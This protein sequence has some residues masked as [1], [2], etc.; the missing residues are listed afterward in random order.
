MHTGE[1]N[2]KENR[3]FIS[4]LML[5]LFSCAIVMSCMTYGV[6]MKKP[7]LEPE[8]S[9]EFENHLAF[10]REHVASETKK[11]EDARNQSIAEV[12][13]EEAAKVA[14]EA[15]AKA[16]VEA[17]VKVE[18]EAKL[19]SVEKLISEV[20]AV[21]AANNPEKVASATLLLAE[22]KD[23]LDEHPDSLE[24][25]RIQYEESEE[26]LVKYNAMIDSIKT[27]LAGHNPSKT[28]D[29]SI[30]IG[31]TEEEFTYLLVNARRSNGKLIIPDAELAKALAKGITEVASEKP[32]NELFSLSIMSLE[33]GW[34]KHFANTNNFGGLKGSKGW[35]S[36]STQ[37]EGIIKTAECQHKNLK[38]NNTARE[39]GASYAPPSDGN[40]RWVGD[41]L[42]IMKTYMQ[43]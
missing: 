32:I 31:F 25:I 34:F 7:E 41:V 15:K 4:R 40:S 22:V 43:A 9:V 35:L 26:G 10:V 28:M 20:N 19:A 11:I 18:A 12:A 17:K 21:Y 6:Q 27:K 33:T 16:E 37:E 5:I 23:I 2:R 3:N 38:G 30:P 24:E 39:V 13:A 29:M 14:A 42:S 8:I 36:F 1:L